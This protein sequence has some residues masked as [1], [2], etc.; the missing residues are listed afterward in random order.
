MP[1]LDLFPTSIYKAPLGRAFGALANRRLADEIAALTAADAAGRRWSARHYLG[2]YTSYGSLDQLHRVATPFAALGRA[3][4]PHADRF[5]RLL[6]WD[7]QGGS[8]AL[9]DCWANVLPAGSGHS[10]H[11]HPNSVLS[12][13]YYVMVPRGAA[14]LKFEDPRLALAM[15]APPRRPSA[16]MARRPFVSVPARAGEVILFESWLRHEVPPA[17][18]TGERISISFNFAWTPRRRPGGSP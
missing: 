3:L 4:A 11:L 5:A 17:R 2:G 6:H 12:G 9:T 1:A 10:L 13:T 7:L 15:A 14:A 8:L 16:P 18:F